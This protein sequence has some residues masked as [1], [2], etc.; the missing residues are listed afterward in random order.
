VFSLS[1]TKN[2][3]KLTSK[4]SSSPRAITGG[5]TVGCA[6]PFAVGAT[7]ANAPPAIAKDTPAAPNTGKAV[8]ERFRFE[9]CFVRAI[10]EPPV[11]ASN[12]PIMVALF[13]LPCI[14]GKVDPERTLQAVNQRIARGSFATDLGCLSQVLPAMWF[15]GVGSS[16]SSDVASVRQ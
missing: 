6:G 8:L 9:A 7:A 2:F 14:G 4:S 11:P 3:D 13:G 5:R 16:R 12:Y 10:V 1:K 15:D